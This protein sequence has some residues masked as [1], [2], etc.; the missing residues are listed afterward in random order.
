MVSMCVF[1]PVRECFG[2]EWQLL[3]LPDT[4]PGQEYSIAEDDNPVTKE[5]PALPPH[6]RHIVLNTPMPPQ[7]AHTLPTPQHVMLNHLSC[8]TILDKLM[9]QAVTVRYKAKAVTAVF[10]SV[11]P[12]VHI[13]GMARS[14]VLVI[15][16]LDSFCR[17]SPKSSPAKPLQRRPSRL[18]IFK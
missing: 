2:V 15:C 16:S 4:L 17:L 9:V 8:T 14:Y 18:T 3:C 10:Y 11:L 12:Q 6:L 13:C 1:L 7:L 5:P